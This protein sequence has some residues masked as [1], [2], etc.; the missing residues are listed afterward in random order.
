MVAKRIQVVAIAPGAYIYRDSCMDVVHYRTKSSLRDPIAH[1]SDA[2]GA[3][4]EAKTIKEVASHSNAPYL[5][6]PLMSPTYKDPIRYEGD[7]F[8]GGSF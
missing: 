7:N 5:D 2:Q 6:H 1:N 8:F 3:I 4:R